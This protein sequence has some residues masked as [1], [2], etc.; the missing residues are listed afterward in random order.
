MNILIVGA[1]MY[2]TGKNNS[3]IGT[4]LASVMQYSKEVNLG[5]VTIYSKSKDSRLAV[6]E[7][8]KR[9]N[10]L[11]GANLHVEH[12]SSEELSLEDLC[13]SYDLNCAIVSTP[14]HLHF[15]QVKCLLSNRI[16]VLCVKPLVVTAEQNKK[17]I[18]V[19]YQNSVLG[20]VEFHKR[21]D[22]ANLFTKDLLTRGGLGKIN[23][24]SVDYSQR[25]S[26]P[27]ET[28]NEWIDKTNIFQY[29]GVH[30]VDLF[31]FMTGYRPI[32]VMA[33]GTKGVLSSRG[34][35]NY[36]SIHANV[37]WQDQDGL[38][39][40]STFNISWVDPN[41]SSAMSDQ[42]YKIVGT[43]GRVENDH[44]H[45]GIELI[46]ETS[47]ISHPNPYFSEM[48]LDENGDYKFSG[49]GYKSIKQ[50]LNDVLQFQA[51]EKDIK[52]FESR[53]PTFTQ[54]LVSSFIIEAVNKSLEKSS[55]WQVID[56]EI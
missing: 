20:M 42:K 36:D 56:V 25:V 8:S 38:E 3:G 52:Y 55:E 44:K 15:E 26:I 24:Y 19:Q 28:F 35:D 16:S 18:E 47:N 49:Y 6:D 2:V 30:Y 33:Y 46:S 29:L 51:G 10:K 11:L 12:I 21:Y 9:L 40:I 13:S 14:D 4:V 41:C 17:L 34:I 37:V 50:F 5:K 7:A 27:T 32:K 22:E 31:Y 43:K 53:R 1:G 23:Y 39:C 45:R 48:L 54:S